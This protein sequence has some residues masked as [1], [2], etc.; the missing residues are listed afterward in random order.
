MNVHVDKTC[1]ENPQ[2]G[3]TGSNQM[4]YT[5][6]KMITETCRRACRWDR[7]TIYMERPFQSPYLNCIENLWTMCKSWVPVMKPTSSN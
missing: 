2:Q 4:K 5:K 7:V 3:N 6:Y 1:E